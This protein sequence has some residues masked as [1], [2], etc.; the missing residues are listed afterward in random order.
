MLDRFI[1]EAR[2][3]AL[4]GVAVASRRL[5][6]ICIAAS[7][8]ALSA[9]GGGGGGGSSPPQPQLALTA[10]PSDLSVVDG[11]RADFTVQASTTASFQWQRESASGAW[12]DIPGATA[13]TYELPAVHSAD[14]GSEYRVVVTSAINAAVRL[15]SSS[16][17]LRVAVRQ[18]APAIVVAPADVSVVQGQVASFSITASGTS[19]AY[20]W[21][22]AAASGTFADVDGAT[23]ATLGLA[24]TTLA[25][26]GSR[27]RVVVS[28]ALGTVAS[29]EVRLAVT[30]A[31]AA[32]VFKQ[33]ASDAT[34]IEGTPATFDVAVVGSPA[35]TLRWQ[36]SRDGSNW[37]DL[38]GQT[39]AS[40]TLA[41]PAVGD[42]GTLFRA[43]ATND[44]G[45][46]PTPPARL[47]VAP[48]PAAPAIAQQPVNAS[49]GVGATPT[50]TVA[51]SGVPAPGYQ[52]QISRDGG[53]NFANVNGATAA[54]YT[55]PATVEGDDGVL[56]RVVISNASGS[57]TSN[58]AA[59]A[60]VPV[61]H[62]SRQPE[63][64]AWHV[65]EGTPMF[66]VVAAGPGLT[67]QWQTRAGAAASFVNVPGETGD[68]YFHGGSTT[69]PTTDVRVQV[70]NA[71]GGVATSDAVQLVALTWRTLHPVATADGLTSIRWVDATTAIAVGEG[72]TIVR[73][74]DAGQTWTAVVEREPAHA[75]RLAAVDFNGAQVGIAVGQGGLIRRTSDG[76]V[77][78]VTVRLPGAISGNYNDR[79]TGLYSVAF[80]DDHT[81]VASDGSSVLLHS[82]D[83][84][85][86]WASSDVG[87][88][89][90]QMAF[91]HG[92]GVAMAD[93]G[94]ARSINGGAQWELVPGS[95]G[96]YAADPLS[97][98]FASDSVIVMAGWQGFARSADGGLTWSVQTAGFEWSL[99]ETVAFADALHGV[100]IGQD[101]NHVEAFVTSD[102]GATWVADAA[103]S[104]VWS[105]FHAVSFNAAGVG[106]LVGDGGVIRR[107]V[108]AGVTW[109][110]NSSALVQGKQSIS[111]VAFPT[112][113][114]GMMVG[115]GTM[116]RTTD[117]GSSWQAVSTPL[118]TST[119]QWSKIVFVDATHAWASQSWGGLA[120]S[121]DGGA[122]WVDRSGALGVWGLHIEDMQFAPDGQTGFVSAFGGGA[123]T[124]MRTTDGGV[125]WQVA[126][127]DST[128]C[129]GDIA[130]G[131][132]LDVIVSDCDGGLEVTHDSGATWAH[133]PAPG[134]NHYELHPVFLDSTTAL[135]TSWGLIFR[136]ADAGRT[137]TMIEN[138]YEINPPGRG[139]PTFVSATEGFMIYSDGSVVHSVDGGQT[140][141]TLAAARAG[142][143]SEMVVRAPHELWGWSG[144]GLAVTHY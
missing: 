109:T 117:G 135:A 91:R 113:S 137:W 126:R 119:T 38:S 69:D 19:L 42:D 49:V 45:S 26:D 88:K 87:I 63:T 103:W 108:D 85:L 27:F 43:V 84:G 89:I 139:W 61:P 37:T 53:A 77:H 8:G 72:G 65:G 7:I 56:L 4:D 67:Y 114:L 35:P 3:R 51:A 80:A 17:T 142:G 100:A 131:S 44:S 112:P 121:S 25:D 59:M 34:V 90:G 123:G 12:A 71:R 46:V 6:W 24:P 13:S 97:I 39:A 31:P 29:G 73:S 9:C 122:T 130:F 54:S 98:T 129:F 21:Q 1:R 92:L 115:F 125:T 93:G 20:Q 76:G 11:D 60:V 127:Q 143:I 144:T 41:S 136:S 95:S 30:P 116:L 124:L 70:T 5:G 75:L 40:F 78:W 55:V 28:N 15:T 128:M 99:L 110:D 32:P 81:V 118:S 134:F 22:R 132:T 106:L 62:I 104:Q 33:V 23:A 107:S 18:T 47:S 14:D 138:S 120:Q 101:F 10:Q 58:A 36:S 102:G 64:Q 50:F 48:R 94:M 86:T 83:A 141:T 2:S 105:D 74:A 68:T 140:W 79:Y 82:D 16:A 111:S 96:V 52:W 133:V 66:Q 57:V